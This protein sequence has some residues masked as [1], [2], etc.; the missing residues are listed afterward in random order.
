MLAASTG[1]Q[2]VAAVSAYAPQLGRQPSHLPNGREPE[3]SGLRALLPPLIVHLDDDDGILKLIHLLLADFGGYRVQS[4]ALARD[5]LDFCH[6]TRPH[7]LITDISRP[8]IDGL[9]VCHLIRND[10]MLRDLRVLI[11]S[12]CVSHTVSLQAHV[13]GVGMMTKPCDP[14]E[15]LDAIDGIMQAQG[16]TPPVRPIR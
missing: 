3:L 14:F 13:L 2:P 4:Y 16:V 5:A 9:T 11:F 1:G 12:A 15:L 10:P 6:Q 8:D 7:L